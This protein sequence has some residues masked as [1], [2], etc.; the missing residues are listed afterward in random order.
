[1]LC[2]VVVLHFQSSVCEDSL[3]I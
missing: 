2:F 3:I 1:M